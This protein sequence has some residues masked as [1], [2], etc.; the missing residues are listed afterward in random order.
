MDSNIETLKVEEPASRS[1]GIIVA[2]VAELLEK[3]RDEAGVL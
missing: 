1:A 2:D 3:L